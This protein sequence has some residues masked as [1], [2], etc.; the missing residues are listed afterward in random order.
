MF[1]FVLAEDRD[2]LWPLMRKVEV[3]HHYRE[4]V[5][6]VGF[7]GDWLKHEETLPLLC[8]PLFRDSTEG[9]QVYYPREGMVES[10]VVIMAGTDTMRID[11]PE[12]QMPLW[13]A[14]MARSN[15][16]TP[17]VIRFRSGTHAIEALFADPWAMRNAKR[18]AER[19]IAEEKAEYKRALAEQEAY[20]RSLTPPIPRSNSEPPHLPTAEEVARAIAQRPGLKQVTIDRVHADTVW[21]RISGRMMLNGGCGSGMPLFGIEMLTDTGW[22]ERIPFELTQMDCGMPWADWEDH[23]VMLHPLRWWV[24]ANSTAAHKELKPGTYRLLFM[25]ANTGLL[26]TEGFEFH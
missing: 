10:Y 25:G 7:S 14:A 5:P 6:Y 22:V 11:L 20:Y 9:W 4:R 8:G 24:A 2:V 13:Q 17:E 3:V 15:R 26:R 21:V 18:I 16:D 1:C 19:L 23:V 12:D